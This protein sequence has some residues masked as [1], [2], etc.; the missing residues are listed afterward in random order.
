AERDP[1][2]DGR[3]GR[4]VM[5]RGIG[6]AD[7]RRQGGQRRIVEPVLFEEGVEAA[8]LADV[9]EL[10]TGD[11]IGDG[12]GLG[13]RRE[14]AGGRH[15]EE[16]G[17]VVDEPDDEPGTGDP[18][19]LRAF[20]GNPLHADSPEVRG[21]GSGTVAAPMACQAAMPPASERASKPRR[22]SSATASPLTWKP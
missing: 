6:A 14:H 16:F 2:E 9:A 15:E 21:C 20:A 22:R 12:A 5:P 7:N 8:L 10:D 11:V 17:I 19:D 18:V 1:L 13:G 3:L 4:Q